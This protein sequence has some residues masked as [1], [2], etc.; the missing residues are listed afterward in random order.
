M[1][2]EWIKDAAAQVRTT[3]KQ[4]VNKVDRIGNSR[5]G[6]PAQQALGDAPGAKTDPEVKELGADKEE[7]GT[8]H[9]GAS[10]PTAGPPC[11]ASTQ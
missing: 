5:V 9:P 3:I 8:T 10:K 2:T 6:R 11:R 7:P 4:A 1:G